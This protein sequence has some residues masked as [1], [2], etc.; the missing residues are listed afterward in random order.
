M[1][2]KK[3]NYYYKLYNI[4]KERSE[5]M[6]QS[7]YRKMRYFKEFSKYVYRLGI[8]QASMRVN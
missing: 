6:H 1:E 7:S 2:H 3:N 5:T 8:P 4:K